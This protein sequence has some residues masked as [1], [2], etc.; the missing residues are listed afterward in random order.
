MIS[1]RLKQFRDEQAQAM[2]EFALVL[3][4]FLAVVLFI[5][6]AG[7]VAIQRTAFDNGFMQTT[8]AVTEEQIRG[9]GPQKE[10]YEAGV[11]D[12][13]EANI[14]ESNIWGL[15]SSNLNVSQAKAHCYNVTNQYE[16]NNSAN[17][18]ATTET[19]YID[20]D[21]VIIYKI[22]PLTYI[23]RLCFGDEIELNKH[24]VTTKVLKS[25]TRSG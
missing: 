5:V 3:P 1:K 23:G 12:A 11:A 10:Y 14:K 8:W 9:G 7:W 13:L 6:E 19:R 18:P 20:L 22:H 2:V 16:V 25:E 21:A 17:L 15:F 24:Y 4:I